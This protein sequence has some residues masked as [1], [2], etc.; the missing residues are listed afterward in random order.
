MTVRQNNTWP[1]GLQSEP[2]AW[3]Q[4]GMWRPLLAVLAG[5]AIPG[6]IAW[7]LILLAGVSSAPSALR[8]HILLV[9]YTWAGSLIIGWLSLPLTWPLALFLA[10]KGW[11]GAT[12]VALCAVSIGMV[13][14][15]ILL[16]GDLTTEAPEALPHL[17]VALVIQGLCG[18]AVLWALLNRSR[19]LP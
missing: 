5:F 1:L 2:I 4:V 12:M 15:H 6:L 9:L 3:Q 17:F 7:G 19:K 16:H 14:A 18:W 11:A 10:V 8:I 13:G